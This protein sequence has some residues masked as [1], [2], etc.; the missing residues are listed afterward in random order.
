MTSPAPSPALK[1]AQ[2]AYAQGRYEESAELVRK[3]L[4]INRSD[5]TAHLLLGMCFYRLGKIREA[6]VHFERCARSSPRWPEPHLRIGQARLQLGDYDVAIAAF[7][8]A[9]ALDPEYPGARSNLAVAL[10]AQGRFDDGLAAIARI[11]TQRKLDATL[12]NARGVALS[13]VKN[14]EGALAAFEAA[15]GAEPGMDNALINRAGC[16]T[17]LLRHEDAIAAFHDIPA[18][19]RS[20]SAHYNLGL[21]QQRLGRF[22][23]ALK[24]YGEALE[25]DP[26]Y[27]DAR[28]NRACL[29]LQLDRWAEGWAG[30]ECRFDATA[31]EPLTS[32]IAALSADPALWPESVLVW[33]E[34]GLGDTLQFARFASMLSRQGP[35]VILAVQ[36]VLVRLLQDLE[37]VCVISRNAALPDCQAQIAL[38][39]LPGL[40]GIDV[41][42]KAACRPYVQPDP[43]LV[44]VWADRLLQIGKV[45]IGI[46]WQGNPDSP[47]DR[48]RSIP[49]EC[50]RSLS[51]QDHVYLI[52]LQQGFGLEQLDALRPGFPV[53]RLDTGFDS[54][55]DAF[56]Q[57]AAILSSLDVL[58]TSDTAIAHL[59]GAMGVPVWV[60]LQQQPDWRWGLW[61][62]NSAWYESA[63]LFRQSQPHNWAEVF[64]RISRELANVKPR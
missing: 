29:N 22:D 58:I 42:E 44:Q 48:G 57:T 3:R 16:L 2:S 20:A 28:W 63:R 61:G 39:S 15:L 18:Q 62:E 31:A 60:V 5:V 1:A 35:R 64:D 9:L 27:H 4:G 53:Q 14:D 38:M 30:Y 26:S 11:E 13:G 8:Q 55:P 52:A 21:S 37:G 34:Q 24:A 41:P 50:F 59:A 7:K 6:L 36:P 17:R 56:I 49:L 45:N 12:L 19:A 43:A 46:Y 51:A 25:I 40:L 23:H 33:S 10:I 54:G 47:A 32:Q